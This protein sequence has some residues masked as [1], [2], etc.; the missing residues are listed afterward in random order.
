MLNII[1]LK[2]GLILYIVK[3]LSD[4]SKNDNLLTIFVIE[5]AEKNSI[6]PLSISI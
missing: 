2:I 3:F 6:I 4:L 1:K 5:S